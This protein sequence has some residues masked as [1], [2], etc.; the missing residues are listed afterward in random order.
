MATETVP[1]TDAQRAFVRENPFV[2]VVTTLRGDGSPHSTVVWVDEENGQIVFNTA[3]GRC[4]PRELRADPRV[5]MLVL[6]PKDAYRWVAVSGTA[7]LTHEGAREHIDRLAKKYLGK[8]D[9]PWHQPGEERVTVRIT[10]DR[11]DSYGI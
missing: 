5:A 10:P 4:K 1:L 3:E 6:D 9:Y 7:E 8:D 2:G 11:V